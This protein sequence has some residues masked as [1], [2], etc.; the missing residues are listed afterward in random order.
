M[1]HQDFYGCPVNFIS[2]EP[3]PNFVMLLIGYVVVMVAV[4]FDLQLE[5]HE[6]S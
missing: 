2:V 3:S 5:Q 6:S 1:R 4:G